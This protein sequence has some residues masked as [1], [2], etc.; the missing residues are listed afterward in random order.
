MGDEEAQGGAEFLDS[1]GF[2]AQAQLKTLVQGGWTTDQPALVVTSVAETKT[3]ADGQDL[4]YRRTVDGG[5]EERETGGSPRRYER[6][7]AFLRKRPGNPFPQMVSVGRAGNSDIV[8][9]LA[10]ISKVHAYFFR[11]ASGSWSLVDQRSRNGTFLNAKR[12]EAGE[13]L[14]LTCGDRVRFA[15]EV[16]VLFVTPDGLAGALA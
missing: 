10:A 7:V 9:R 1:E 2:V 3:R 16:T 5:S 15:A 4:A 12:L 6:R 8:I 13:R 11:E 14:P